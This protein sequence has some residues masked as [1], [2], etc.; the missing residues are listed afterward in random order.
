MGIEPIS[1]IWKTDILT[2]IRMMQVG[3]RSAYFPA[4]YIILLPQWGTTLAGIEPDLSRLKISRP[5][6]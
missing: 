3:V 4:P 2:V 5:N 6:Q 1:S